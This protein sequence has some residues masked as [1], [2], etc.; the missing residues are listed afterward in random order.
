MPLVKSPAAASI[1]IATSTL[2]CVNLIKI[3]KF[4]RGTCRWSAGLQIGASLDSG[5]LEQDFIVWLMFNRIVYFVVSSSGCWRLC[6]R[7]RALGLYSFVTLF[8]VLIQLCVVETLRTTC[9]LSES[10]PP[11]VV[12]RLVRGKHACRSLDRLASVPGAGWR[13]GQLSHQLKQTGANPPTAHYRLLQDWLTR[14]GLRISAGCSFTEQIGVT[15][16]NSLL[17]PEEDGPEHPVCSLGNIKLTSYL[18][19]VNSRH[20]AGSM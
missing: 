1:T 5:E 7:R 2:D 11:P 14:E 6:G 8:K 19:Q 3:L 20:S 9:V 18:L 13:E 16:R 4:H 17:D 10:A 15:D 12:L